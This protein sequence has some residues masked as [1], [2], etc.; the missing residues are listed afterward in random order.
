MHQSAAALRSFLFNP[1]SYQIEILI[2]AGTRDIFSLN[3]FN[4]KSLC[5]FSARSSHDALRA[6]NK[7]LPRSRLP[8][9]INYENV[10]RQR[11][12]LITG[13]PPKWY[14]PYLNHIVFFDYQGLS[15][16][17]VNGTAIA[18]VYNGYGSTIHLIQDQIHALPLEQT[19]QV[20]NI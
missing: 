17:T 9:V 18:I 4:K 5:L 20:Q 13:I 3:E 7:H 15:A 6:A 19:H 8:R 14:D 10:N 2:Q 12:L 11:I 1:V 16:I